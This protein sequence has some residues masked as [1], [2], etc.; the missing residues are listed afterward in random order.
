MQMITTVLIGVLLAMGGWL[1][2][3]TLATE[4]PTPTNQQAAAEI[5]SGKLRELNAH[6]LKKGDEQG[7]WRAVQMISDAG[8][9]PIVEEIDNPET[10]PPN[11]V[12]LTFLH[13]QGDKPP[14]NVLLFANINH[15]VP[16][17]LIFEKVE[18]TDVYFKTVEV[19]RGVRFEYRIIENDPLTGL[20][21]GAKYGTRMH[22]LGGDPDPLNPN[23]RV[24][25]DGLRAGS[26]YI[27]TWG[28]LSQITT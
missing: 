19:P 14:S 20:F 3:T 23:K 8:D 16:A 28:Q 10:S 25:P 17:E 15:V 26:D 12:Q 13:R 9:Y 1:P 24:F 11:Y 4:S 6:F 27:K 18:G 5:H 2:T 22:V 7:F 21:A